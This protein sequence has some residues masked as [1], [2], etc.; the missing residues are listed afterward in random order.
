MLFCKALSYA[1]HLGLNTESLSDWNECSLDLGSEQE[2]GKTL[3]TKINK[4]SGA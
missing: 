4:I 1:S 2:P 3:R